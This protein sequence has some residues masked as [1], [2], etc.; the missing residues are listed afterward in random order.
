M[1][2]ILKVVST[3]FL[4]SSQASILFHK[5]YYIQ[6]TL[7]SDFVKV[8]IFSS[9]VVASAS[10]G[11]LGMLHFALDLSG[12]EQKQIWVIMLDAP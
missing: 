4:W 2:P 9:W 1:E 11:D 3:F 10:F 7:L 12:L 8:F 5:S 6:K